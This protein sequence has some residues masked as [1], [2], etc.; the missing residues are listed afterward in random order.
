MESE[1]ALLTSYLLGNQ[2]QDNISL[3]QFTSLF[4][5]PYRSSPQVKD[6]YREFQDHRDAVR[7]VVRKNI[8]IELGISASS[9]FA[10]VRP[11]GAMD[12]SLNDVDVENSPETRQ[13]NLQQSIDVLVEV[14]SHLAQQ[15]VSME[16]EIYDIYLPA[17]H[18]LNN[19]LSSIRIDPPS[20]AGLP[21]VVSDELNVE[22]IA[23]L[24]DLVDFCDSIQ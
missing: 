23:Q 20:A 13:L 11:H 5:A 15:I 8:A 21:S 16:R 9:T 18:K 17:F 6:L 22:V 3:K 24:K 2:L 4:Q 19:D 7:D 14:E 10:P 1:E 12:T